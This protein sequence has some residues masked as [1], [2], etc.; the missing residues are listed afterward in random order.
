[1]RNFVSGLCAACLIVLVGC[2]MNSGSSGSSLPSGGNGQSALRHIAADWT[3]INLAGWQPDARWRSVEDRSPDWMQRGGNYASEFRSGIGVFGYSPKPNRSNMAPV[4]SPPGN[5]YNVN[6]IASDRRGNLMVP[7]ST[8]P[9]RGGQWNV[10]VYLGDAQPMICGALIAA[11]PI[12]S[13][14]PVDASSVDVTRGAALIAISVIDFTTRR[15]EVLVC[16]VETVVRCAPSG[17]ATSSAITGFSAGVVMDL[18]GNCW[19]STSKRVANGIPVGFRLVYWAGCAGNGVVATGTEGQSSYGG[20]FIDNAG[21]IG[22][23]D[24]FNSRLHVYS[25]CNPACTRLASFRLRG[26]SFFGGLNGAGN[27]LAVGDSTNGSVDVYRYDLSNF[28]YLYSFNSGL[29][30][31]RLVMSGIFSPSNLRR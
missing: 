25:G 26:Q 21:N 22:A 8:R 30:R 12:T 2:S 13:G 1:M 19:L 18:S 3:P 28:E 15:G 29:R 23:F 9:G 17:P 27:R 24:A 16:T 4:C 5:R 6:G 31:S 10:S 14:Q 7:G 11:I 20:L